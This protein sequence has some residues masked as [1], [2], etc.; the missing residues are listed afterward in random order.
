MM[1][2]CKYPGIF[3]QSIMDLG[4]ILCTYKKPKCLFCPIKN[5]CFSAKNGTV[6]KFPVKMT[7]K[8]SIKNRF[9]Y[10][11]I[12]H[13]HN[14]N[15]CIHKRSKNDIWKG[16][17]EFPLIESDKNLNSKKEI[18]DLV[19]N[20]FNLNYYNDII[21]KIKHKLTH[22]NL[23]IQFLNCKIL[24]KEFNKKKFLKR[25]I[26]IPNNKIKEYPFPRPI[27]LFFKYNKNMI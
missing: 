14:G 23:L 9:F 22:Q 21:Y 20:R 4:S 8:H 25:F 6:N 2:N 24:Q 27:I 1:K 19:W 18:I 26:F 11:I 12:L 10:Y 15:I 13:D 16:L 17:Y 5:S 7:K 3:N